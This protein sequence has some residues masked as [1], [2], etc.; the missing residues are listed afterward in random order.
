[1]NKFVRIIV[2]SLFLCFSTAYA[3]IERVSVSSTGE[4]GNDRSNYPA[5]SA[6]G[7]YV[8][9]ASAAGNFV[10]GDTNDD[11][12][13]IFLHDQQ[14]GET[15]LVNVSSAGEQANRG[16]SEFEKFSLSAD[17][18]FVAF[19][20]Y[21]SNLVQND[22]NNR[23]DVFVRDRQTGVTE[24]VSVSSSGKPG[25]NGGSF[26]PSVSAGGRYVAFASGAIGLV[27]GD[28]NRNRDVFV[29]DRQTGVTERV[30]VSSTGEQGNVGSLNPSLSADGRFVAFQSYASNLVQ[31]DTNNKVDVF[32]HD[33]QTGVTE[34]VSESS[35]GEQGNSD[36][37][38][39]SL[40][41][42]GRY[43]AFASRSSH[44]VRGDTNRM[45]DIFVHDRQTGVTERVSVSAVGEQ[46][47]GDSLGPSLSADGR[48]VAFESYASNLVQVDTNDAID[49]FIHDRETGNIKRINITPS[50]E[51][52]NNSESR[53]PVLSA[54]GRYVAFESDAVDLVDED[55]NYVSDTFVT[56]NPLLSL[57]NDFITVE[58][59]INNEVRGT[60]ST[61]AQLAAGTLYKQSYKVTNN[62]A[63]RIY[64]AKVFEDANLVC[65]FYSLNPGES[66]ERCVTYQA[67]L[68]G[69][70]HSQVKVT[71]KASGSGEMLTGNTD[72]YYTGLNNVTGELRVTHRV[73]NINADV[74]DQ[75]QTLG[76]QQANVLFKIENTGEIELYQVKAYHDPVSPMNSGWD[77]QCVTGSMKPGDIRYCKRDIILTEP[78]LNQAMGR[79]QGRNA[80]KSATNVINASNST[81]FIVP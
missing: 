20:S 4:Q 48:Y 51:Q 47:N 67:V 37:F 3:D 60:R 52:L 76:P 10:N 15:E 44:N 32:V 46:A 35:T 42:D 21:A 75:A 45:V 78:G 19:E 65:N 30:S 43:V 69:D 59:R 14:T 12:H 71:A 66:R 13:D 9:F 34:R 54:D 18:R 36:S 33:R 80:I 31:N 24:I 28:T 38:W 22:T 5:L 8:V 7:R 74:V 50:G 63:N 72:A 40:S 64:Q 56:D 73:N 81:Y 57:D 25:N 39:P 16:G 49:V 79:V 55:T 68:D 1:M 53:F 62:S 6:D 23:V 27:Y 41:S 26:F 77:L 58:K 17:G 2:S 11:Y 61:A 29:H 70:L